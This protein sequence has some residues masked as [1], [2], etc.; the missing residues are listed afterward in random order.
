MQILKKILFCIAGMQSADVFSAQQLGN[1]VNVAQALQAAINSAASNNSTVIVKKPSI[2]T[3]I[4]V[5]VPSNWGTGNGYPPVQ[6]F[7]PTLNVLN[8]PNLVNATAP[9]Y[10]QGGLQ[11]INVAL[12][13]SS[14]ASSGLLF[15][16][17]DMT[18]AAMQ[19]LAT[20]GFYVLINLTQ[21]N[22]NN[23]AQVLLTDTKGN[24]QATYTSQPLPANCGFTWANIGFNSGDTLVSNQSAN[25][26]YANWI[27]IAN[28][29]GVYYQNVASATR[30][31]PGLGGTVRPAPAQ[32]TSVTVQGNWIGGGGYP[33]IAPF[34]TTPNVLTN[35]AVVNPSAPLHCSG[36]LQFINVALL[37]ADPS[38]Q[39]LAFPNIVM[40]TA[41]MQ[42]LAQD[43]FYVLVNL[44]QL[45][46]NNVAQV[47]LTD[48]K[49]NIQATYTSQALPANCGFT[50]ANIGFNASDSVSA[51]Q[52]GNATYAN[53]ILIENEQ[54]VFY[55]ED[56]EVASAPSLGGIVM[57]PLTVASKNITGTIPQGQFASVTCNVKN[58][59]NQAQGPVT[60][61]GGLVPPASGAV[62]GI[63]YGIC[64][65]LSDADNN[66]SLAFQ[67][68]PNVLNQSTIAPLLTTGQTGSA[69]LYIGTNLI[70]QDGANYAQVVLMDQNANVVAQ[71]LSQPLPA[72][73]GFVYM[74]VLFNMNE[75][76]GVP[77]DN[78]VS[79][80]WVP[81]AQGQCVFYQ[82]S[83]GQSS[84]S[85][86]IK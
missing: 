40:T 60:C 15:P 52:P 11:F 6:V 72:S 37:S 74:N 12:F 79:V 17:I 24:V 69:G 51:T 59:F 62:P 76:T 55:Q 75:N 35:I 39:G 45:N 29:H 10:C 78:Q 4:N 57:P 47:V 77:A 18:S 58:V 9:L 7:V 85:L 25:A 71:G 42:T 56:E 38:I 5:I 64:I 43:G 19:T 34:I 13:G 32:S 20:N 27:P 26:T 53:W 2:P 82:Q 61:S 3:P 63:P 1:A 65:A 36:G 68:T 70:T 22:G 84:Q 54:G 33:P 14:A 16:N 73:A 80:Y 49:G 41:V 81:I 8:A 48:T 31:A 83:S 30:S 23:V 66:N 28:Q 21:L 67:I 50:W 46:G 44:T 86:P